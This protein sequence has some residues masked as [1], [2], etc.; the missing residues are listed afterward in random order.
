MS[1]IKEYLNLSDVFRSIYKTDR[2]F[3]HLLAQKSGTRLGRIYETINKIIKIKQILHKPLHFS[4]NKA[5]T[6][7]LIIEKDNWGKGNWKI[8]NSIL[9]NN[10]YQLLIKKLV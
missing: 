10:D 4:D 1:K 3:T 8:N 7:D 6:I 2:V 9:V 5:I